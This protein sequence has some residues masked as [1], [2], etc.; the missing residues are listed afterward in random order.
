MQK[1]IGKAEQAIV[2]TVASKVRSHVI[3]K[4]D[5]K[6]L[7]TFFNHRLYRDVKSVHATA[8]NQ[9]IWA[10]KLVG[11]TFRPEFFVTTG[12]TYPLLCA[13]CK[14]LTDR[15]AKPRFKEGLSQALLYSNEYKTVLLVF[16]DFT[17]GAKYASAFVTP[18]TTEHNLAV[19]L[20]QAHNILLIFLVPV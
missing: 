9:R 13:E 5:K 6:R 1:R 14:K 15:T 18:Y 2:N 12:K 17:S 19:K 16:Y 11:E 3:F 8:T 20:W 7:E 10:A 4:Q